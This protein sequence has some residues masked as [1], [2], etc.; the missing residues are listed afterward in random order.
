MPYATIPH[1]VASFL[2]VDEGVEELSLVSQE[3]LNYDTAVADLFQCAPPSSESSLLFGQR[4][5][6][7]TFQSIEDNSKH[8]FDGMLDN[9][10]GVV[11]LEQLQPVLFRLGDDQ[12]LY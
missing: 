9:A 6:G 12:C 2:Q 3:F 1:A 10:D 4:F 8:D 7:L 11:N 5:L